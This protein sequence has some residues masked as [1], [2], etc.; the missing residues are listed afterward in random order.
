MCHVIIHYE[1]ITRK[2]MITC[3]KLNKQTIML[4]WAQGYNN[5]YI[6][7]VY[8]TPAFEPRFV[9][10][11]SCIL[12]IIGRWNCCLKTNRL[13]LL[14]QLAAWQHMY[15]QG[16][17][18]ASPKKRQTNSTKWAWWGAYSVLRWRAG[19][20]LFTFVWV[21]PSK[22]TFYFINNIDR[23]PHRPLCILQWHTASAGIYKNKI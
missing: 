15:P 20:S 4:L 17:L 14:T 11:I 8:T 9:C 6:Y 3:L 5:N 16:L 7:F 19:H 18:S 21:S 13:H 2:T 22:Q 23:F 1:W 12:H 10:P